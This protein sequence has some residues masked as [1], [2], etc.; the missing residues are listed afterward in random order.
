MGFFVN[1]LAIQTDFSA[2]VSLRLL[3]AQVR[4]SVLDAFDH[5]D[6]PFDAVVSEV[7][8]G[9]DR[10][11]MPVVQTMLNFNEFESVHVDMGEHVTVTPYELSHLQPDLI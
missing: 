9:R 10:S 4:R 6:V 7:L 8:T 1:T 11:R 2:D 5:Q 3:L